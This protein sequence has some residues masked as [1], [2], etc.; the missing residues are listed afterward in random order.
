MKEEII[1]KLKLVQAKIGK[2]IRLVERNERTESIIIQINKTQK[3]LRAVRCLILKDYL[4]K[5]TRQTGLPEKEILKYHEL[6]N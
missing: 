5:I 6:I 1:K 2:I 3:M 4:I